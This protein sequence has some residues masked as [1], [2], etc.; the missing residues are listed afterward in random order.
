MFPRRPTARLSPAFF[1]Y[2]RKGQCTTPDRLKPKKVGS[3]SARRER[4]YKRAAETRGEKHGRLPCGRA[5]GKHDII[6]KIHNKLF[7]SRQCP[8]VERTFRNLLYVYGRGRRRCT[9]PTF[10]MPGLRLMLTPISG[11]QNDPCCLLLCPRFRQAFLPR[12]ARRRVFSPR[13]PK[14]RRAS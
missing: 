10:G 7:Q 9:D 3:K 5:T 11:L 2:K 14:C 1:T 6:E 12:S 4:I 13:P 8:S